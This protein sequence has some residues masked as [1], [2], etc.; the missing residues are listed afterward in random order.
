MS[1]KYGYFVRVVKSLVSP[2]YD[3]TDTSSNCCQNP[4]FLINILELR[5][6]RHTCQKLN[7]PEI[8]TFRR[9]W[10]HWAVILSTAGVGRI[11]RNTRDNRPNPLQE[12]P[13]IRAPTGG[14]P[15]IGERDSLGRFWRRQE[16][17]LPTGDDGDD[18]S[19]DRVSIR[20]RLR[21]AIHCLGGMSALELGERLLAYATKFSPVK[22]LRKS[23][24]SERMLMNLSVISY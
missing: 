8:Q 17:Q 7:V 11:T 15:P 13:P 14:A 24:A 5:T 16:N 6:F 2:N 22:N 3:T 18:D 9:T 19:V 23:P 21:P 12:I 4:L 10:K 20:V 1:L